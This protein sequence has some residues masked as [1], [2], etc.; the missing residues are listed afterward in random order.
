MLYSHVKLTLGEI[1]TESPNDELP[2]SGWDPDPMGPGWYP[3]PLGSARS[4]WWDGIGWTS[5]FRPVPTTTEPHAFPARPLISAETPVLNPFI[6]LIV[7]LPLA[8]NVLQLAWSPFARLGNLSPGQMSTG[9][10]TPLFAPASLL[11]LAGSLVIDGITILLAYLDW[12]RLREEGVLRP[13]HWA[14]GFLTVIYVIGRTLVVRQVA[15]GRG[16]EPIWAMVA[17]FLIALIGSL[18]KANIPYPTIS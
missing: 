13:F 14:W 15:P 4:R 10:P 12:R 18:I 16:L 1:V 2:G 9:D 5:D 11:V 3:D 6:W 17:V 7:F 8:S